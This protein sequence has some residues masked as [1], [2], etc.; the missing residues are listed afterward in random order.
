MRITTSGRVLLCA[1]I[2]QVASSADLPPR[3]VAGGVPSL[4]QQV[5]TLQSQV[6]AQQ[7][8]IAALQNQVAALMAGVQVT[9]NGVVVQGPVVTLSGGNIRLQA[10]P[11]GVIEFNAGRLAALTQDSISLR[12]GTTLDLQSGTS[13]DVRASQNLS[14]KAS[15]SALVQASGSLDLK[16]SLTRLNGGG[17]AVATVGSIVQVQTSAGPVSGQILTGSP[18]VASD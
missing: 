8:Q 1:A 6:A 12:S 17:K 9:P 11:P 2:C 14:V 5:A 15:G 4:Q 3:P 7:S 10:P 16:G 18:D 13:T